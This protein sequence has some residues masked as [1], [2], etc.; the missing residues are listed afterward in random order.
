M[1]RRGCGQEGQGFWFPIPMRGNEVSAVEAATA[2]EPK[3]P[4]PMRGN[5]KLGKFAG[6]VLANVPNPH[7]G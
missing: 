7:E 3:F 5:E 2:G 6:R 4:I 1:S